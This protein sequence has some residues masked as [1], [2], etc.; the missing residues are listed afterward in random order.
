VNFP[1]PTLEAIVREALG[2]PDREI[3]RSDLERFVTLRLRR[4]ISN[5]SGLE[6]AVN[7]RELGHIEGHRIEDLRPLSKLTHL[8]HLSLD[9]D[10]ISDIS[11]LAN[12][13][14]LEV[15]SLDTNQIRDIS[16]LS[17]MT[18][19]RELSLWRN[20]INDISLFSKLTALRSVS[21]EGNRIEDISPLVRNRGIQR[22]GH[23]RLAE[24]PL[25]ADSI[26][27]YIPQLERR[28]VWV[29]W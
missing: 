29:F 21:L 24:N 19:L 3:H 14:N 15:L 26:N 11:P 5:L 2:E 22:W 9:E 6:Y 23:I 13:V 17:N 16:A 10:P 7:L 12:L 27:V 20:Q 4:G 8:R 18:S 1:D 28:D 25:S